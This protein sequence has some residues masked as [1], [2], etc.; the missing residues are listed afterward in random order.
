L[1]EEKMSNYS[2]EI[3]NLVNAALD[4][5]DQEHKKG[6][7]ADTPV[8]NTHFL[9]RWVTRALKTQR[10][11]RIVGDDLT[12]WQKA[13]RSKGTQSDLLFTFRN[14]SSFYGHFLPG[15]K[16]APVL[17]DADIE[18]LLD[19]AEQDNWSVC[20]EYDLTEKIQLFTEGDNSLVLCAKQCE[21]CFSNADDEGREELVKP[22]SLFVRGNHARFVELA[23]R[24]GFLV[25]K[26]TAYKSKVKYHGEYLIYPQNQGAQLAEIPIGFSPESY[27]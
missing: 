10:F 2:V 20:T 13:G 6:K 19:S 24:A 1:E 9:V 11:P 5:L 12:R 16:A 17:R 25:H 18:A 8:S 21:A 4:E 22:M 7:L 15:D 3:Q 23:T 27:S 26:V 14:I